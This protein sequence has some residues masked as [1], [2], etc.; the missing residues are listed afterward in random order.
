MHVW[1]VALPVHGLP[2]WCL[3]CVCMCASELKKVVRFFRSGRGT[4]GDRLTMQHDKS[5]LGSERMC[6][7]SGTPS[8]QRDLIHPYLAGMNNQGV[9]SR[10]QRDCLLPPPGCLYFS[11]HAAGR[12]VCVCVCIG[13]C[14]WRCKRWN[15]SSRTSRTNTMT[16]QSGRANELDEQSLTQTS[17]VD[18][19]VSDLS[20]SN[21]FN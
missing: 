2:F 18:V 10:N 9:G 4:G 16:F 15:K 14:K 5:R 21:K 8:W 1:Q 11:T 6:R 17:V 20:W 13:G 7:N 12:C 19:I 3:V